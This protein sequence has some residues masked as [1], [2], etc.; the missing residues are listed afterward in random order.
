M[1]EGYPLLTCIVVSILL[2]VILTVRYK[3][4]PFF[5]L[6]ISSIVLGIIVRMPFSVLLDSIEGGFG[7]MMKVIGLIVI[8]GSVIGVFLESS[9][10]AMKIATSILDLVGKKRT[11]TAIG[12][13]G[14]TV[15]I[16]VF[17]DSGFI[18]LSSLSKKLSQLSK[19]KGA[20]LSLGLA[21]GLYTT[22]T[23]VPPTPG[24]IAA[25][26]NIGA[27]DYLGT[28]ILMGLFISIPV[29]IVAL[30]FSKKLGNKIDLDLEEIEDNENEK[31]PSLWSSLIPLLLPIGLIAL[32]TVLRFL[33]INNTWINFISD[34]VISILLGAL[35][36][37]LLLS[38]LDKKEI[39]TWVSK[40]IKVAGPILIITGAGGAF[41]GVLKATPI[42]DLVSQWLTTDT[43][44]IWV[45]IS[46][47]GIAALLKTAQGSSTNA[48]IIASSLLAPILPLIGWDEPIYLALAVM[49]IGGGAMTVSHYND[50]Y[51]WVVSQFSGM[52]AKDT[53]R[54]F[55]LLTG[56]QGVTVLTCT[57]AL[58]YL[59]K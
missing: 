36:A 56:I 38:P 40:A 51:F 20:T 39:G 15:S 46:V 3:V 34:P 23:L 27:T 2:I 29:L 47:F 30:F 7:N 22:H 21:T 55:T 13:I 6:I 33:G 4:H 31:L 35:L 19:T 42:A 54:S 26:G 14:A 12:L 48:M 5:S 59:F 37:I 11:L 43:S 10:G 57:I 18:L 17:C 1:I 25:A 16:P 44:G 52:N 45:L 49:A 32:G 28:I 53:N 58:Y 24:P 41:G 9:G 8:F 50:S